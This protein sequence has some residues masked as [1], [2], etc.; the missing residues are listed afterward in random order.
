MKRIFLLIIL[1]LISG[2]SIQKEKQEQ[3]KLIAVEKSLNQTLIEIIQTNSDA[4][5][6]LVS[7]PNYEIISVEKFY[8][9]DK[10]NITDFP[11]E[12]NGLDENKEYYE[13]KIKSKSQ[14]TLVT[15]IDL[16]NKETKSAF[17]IFLMSIE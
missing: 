2:C 13:M 17:G 12:Y 9:K 8:K 4:N 5:E 10:I 3:T 11:N 15:I 14:L 7:N 16:E 6:Y 1:I